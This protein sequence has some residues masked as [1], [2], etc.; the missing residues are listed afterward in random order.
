MRKFLLAD[1]SPVRPEINDDDFAFE[2]LDRSRQLIVLGYFDLDL[3]LAK[4]GQGEKED[5]GQHYRTPSIYEH[6]S[7]PNG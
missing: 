3:V 5:Y 6:E 2:L 1:Q 7:P 4:S